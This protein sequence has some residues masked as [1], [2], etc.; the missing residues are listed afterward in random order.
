MKITIA[1]VAMFVLPGDNKFY[2]IRSNL[3]NI[4]IIGKQN[5]NYLIHSS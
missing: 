2:R 4:L 3:W 1:I 5:L